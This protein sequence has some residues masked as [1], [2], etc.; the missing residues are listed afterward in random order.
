[1][2]G[3]NHSEVRFLK[4]VSRTDG[5]SIHYEYA[6]ENGL[7]GQ[8]KKI[9]YP[10]GR[11]MSVDYW[12]VDHHLKVNGKT[13]R[14]DKT[15]DDRSLFKV[16]KLLQ[17]AGADGKM[18]QTH[19]FEYHKKKNDRGAWTTVIDCFDN[20]DQYLIDANYRLK[21]IQYHKGQ[22]DKDRVESFLGS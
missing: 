1:M 17:P 16:Q 7:N 4:E 19:S 15:N 6:T 5:P 12:N 13:V 22:S 9:A 18:V 11:G 14:L 20:K 8:L 21:E 3:A 2:R 10:D